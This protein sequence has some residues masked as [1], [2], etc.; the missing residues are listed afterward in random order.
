MQTSQDV[1][2]QVREGMRVVDARDE[3]VGKVQLVRMGDPES[4]TT[5][6][7]EREPTELVGRIAEAILP[8]EEEP[9]VPEPLRTKLVRTGYIKIDGPG[10]VDTDRYASPEQIRAVDDDTVRL[11]VA[12]KQ[13]P[14]EQ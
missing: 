2:S 5:A 14:E 13:L 10:L 4:V 9:D 12:R 8:D 6:G 3:S 1:M 11:K 7:N